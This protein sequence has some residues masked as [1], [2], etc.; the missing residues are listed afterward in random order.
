MKKV[1]CYINQ[2]KVDG[3]EVYLAE[4]FWDRLVG[5]MFLKKERMHGLILMNSPSIH[6]CFM[7]FNIDVVFINSK[8]IVTKIIRNLKP[9]SV[10][11]FYFDTKYVLELPSGTLSKDAIEGDTLEMKYV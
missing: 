11:S 9:W 5:L 3:S 2:K 1:N 6:T 7:R 4:T 8:N 10:T